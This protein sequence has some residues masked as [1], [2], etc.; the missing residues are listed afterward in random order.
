MPTN[1]SP[2]TIAEWF[3][4]G[5]ECFR[6]PDGVGAV[7][8]LTHVIELNPG[9]CH[10]DGDNPYFYLGKIH[11]VEGRIEDAISHYSRAI[12]VNERDEESLIGRGSCYTV[13][14][15]HLD[16]IADFTKVLHFPDSHRRVPKQYLLYA[17]A[18]NY[19][20][21]EDW[22]NALFWGKQALQED[23]DNYR[24]QQLVDEIRQKMK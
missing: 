5:R 17:I 2:R 19:R 24:H 7:K 13:I 9:Y 12:S 1:K 8:A 11:E 15:K 23:P 18:E 21:M 16:A 3:E 22:A 14:K 6:K 4:K 20:Q 10:P